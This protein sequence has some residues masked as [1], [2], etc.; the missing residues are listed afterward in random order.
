MKPSNFHALTAYPLIFFTHIASATE[1]TTEERLQYH[2]KR[3]AETA[4][5]Q[6]ELNKQFSCGFTG[7]RWNDDKHGQNQW[8][9]TV[10]ESISEAEED[11]RADLLKQCYLKKADPDNPDNHPAIPA[12]CKTKKATPVRSIYVPY[13]NNDTLQ[14]P[15]QDGHIRYDFNE[16]QR[17][18]HAYL[19]YY[20]E[21]WHN[22]GNPENPISYFHYARLTFCLSNG[23]QWLRYPT[24]FNMSAGFTNWQGEDINHISMSGNLLN[25]TSYY[26]EHNVGSSYIDAYYKFDATKSEFVVHSHKASASPVEYPDGPYPMGAPGTHNLKKLSD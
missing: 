26:L 9:L 25:I 12:T 22:P 2:C 6:H 21:Q 11:A 10:R 19:E 14:I 5:Q 17:L 13:H 18:D 16:D 4:T 24:R 23:E 20:K 8:C 15:V 3:Y 1:W 7:S